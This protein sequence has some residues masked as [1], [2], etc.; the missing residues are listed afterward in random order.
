MDEN[1]SDTGSFAS[2]IDDNV[3]DDD[4]SRGDQASTTYASK[5]LRLWEQ[6]EKVKPGLVQA[7]IAL[8]AAP[9]AQGSSCSCIFTRPIFVDCILLHC[10]YAP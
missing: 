6:W 1:I 10:S 3:N 8:Q 5:Q 9:E 4:F 7:L 2:V